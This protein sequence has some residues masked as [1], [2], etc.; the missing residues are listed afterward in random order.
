MHAFTAKVIVL[1]KSRLASR[2][3]SDGLTGTHSGG[4]LNR[5][6]SVP[7]WSRKRRACAGLGEASQ[8]NKAMRST[9]PFPPE[10]DSS[11]F[12]I[13]AWLFIL[14]TIYS[15]SVLSATK[16]WLLHFGKDINKLKIMSL[17]VVSG[18]HTECSHQYVHITVSHL[19]SQCRAKI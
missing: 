10:K 8:R 7:K 4:S 15:S 9:P 11:R 5:T 13:M 6:E 2:E 16:R 1:N 17:E 19:S 12:F 18:C 14:S 3:T